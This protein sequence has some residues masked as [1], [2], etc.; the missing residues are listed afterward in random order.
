MEHFQ[1]LASS[2]EWCSDH[3]GGVRWSFRFDPRR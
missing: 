2:K 1:T 3:T